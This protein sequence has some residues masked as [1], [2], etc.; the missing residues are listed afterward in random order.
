MCFGLSI[1]FSIKTVS[2]PKD[3]NASLFAFTKAVFISS[4]FRITRIPLPPPPAAAF[5]ITG[6]P[7]EIASDKA[8]STVFKSI[9]ES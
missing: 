7:I 5:N 2:S 4:A 1:N 3:F 6:K 9:L 8:S